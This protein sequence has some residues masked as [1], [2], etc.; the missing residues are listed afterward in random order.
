MLTKYFKKMLY[1]PPLPWAEHCVFHNTYRLRWH[2][3]I[4]HGLHAILLCT[5]KKWVVGGCNQNHGIEWNQLLQC[6]KS[7][8]VILPNGLHVVITHP[9]RPSLLLEIDLKILTLTLQYGHLFLM[10]NDR[11]VE[12]LKFTHGTCEIILLN[13]CKGKICYII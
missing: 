5:I 10:L 3:W 12:N 4:C 7:I 9:S 6:E 11:L 8:L 13:Y 1:F 2:C